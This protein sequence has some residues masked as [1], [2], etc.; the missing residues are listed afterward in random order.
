MTAVAGEPIRLRAYDKMRAQVAGQAV[1]FKDVALTIADVDAASRLT[2]KI[3]RLPQTIQPSHAFF[4]LNGNT[5]RIDPSLESRRPLEFLPRPEF[6]SGQPERQT[7]RR[8][9]EA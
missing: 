4:L 1:K 6:H 2:Q 5:R 3:N 8:N 7:V 9:R